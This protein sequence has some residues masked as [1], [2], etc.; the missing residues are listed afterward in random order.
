M[1]NGTVKFFSLAKG[2]GFVA[3]ADGSKDVYVHASVL[4]NA[5]VDA[6]KPGQKVSFAAEPK[7][8]GLEVTRIEVAEQIYAP[9]SPS[10]AVRIYF[11]PSNPAAADVVAAANEA[12]RGV[13][14]FDYAATALSHDQ[15][16]HLSAQLRAQ[17]QGLVLRY[18]PLFFELQLDDRFIGENEFWTAVA[19]HPSLIDG[20]VLVFGDK[21]GICKNGTDVR[22]LLGLQRPAASAA[23]Q[24]GLPPRM[25]AAFNLPSE[26][27][28][29]SLEDEGADLPLPVAKKPSSIGPRLR[30]ES[31]ARAEAKPKV[32]STAK[33][34]AT[35][36][37]TVSRKASK[38]KT[39]AD[40][41]KKPVKKAKPKA[42]RKR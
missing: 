18:A 23:K 39:V 5:G 27:P 14:L 20:P 31:E 30:V 17:G 42:T 33:A 15:L 19:E 28:R 9:K 3:P 32:K 34:K 40:A 38:P 36:A 24:S 1:I 16:R 8:K 4:K 6:L 12:G 7:T 10:K 13:Q 35:P 37:T 11:D 26:T 25:A 29:I 22:I 41:K 21:V 2:F